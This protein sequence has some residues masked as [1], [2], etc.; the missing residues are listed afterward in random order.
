[1]VNINSLERDGLRQAELCPRHIMKMKTKNTLIP[2]RSQPGITMTAPSVRHR[3]V[4]DKYAA[5]VPKKIRGRE[6]I[7]VGTLNVRTLGPAGKLEQLTHA[8]SRYHWN[9]VGLCEMRWKNFGEMSTDDG[10]K[11][12]FSGEEGKHEYG[13][14]FLV[15]KDVGWLVGCFGF[16]GPLR[17]FQ[18][19]SGRLPKTG[20]KRK[21]RIDE[22]KND[23]T[24]PTRTYCKC[25]RPLPYC[26]PNCRT[27]RHWKITQQH[28]TTR[29][30]THKDVVDAVLGCQPV[31]SRLIS[32]R[33]RAAPFNITIIQLYA[34]TS[35]HDDSEVDHFYQKLQETID[36]TPKKDILVVQG[37]WNAKVGKDAQA[38]LG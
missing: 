34:P 10:H 16:N 17:V 7:A 5:G 23:Q 33:L 18:S 35:G 27:P 9:I 4:G 38:N 13:V 22:S 24:T 29:P 6:N 19:I 3:D 1:M 37:D 32:I 31:S 8:M 15:H 14:G 2:D 21:E 11:V 12:Y 28:R 36:Q 25:S 26:Y 30:P 20:R